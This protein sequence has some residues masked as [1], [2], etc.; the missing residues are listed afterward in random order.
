M[1]HQA[2]IFNFVVFKKEFVLTVAFQAIPFINLSV[3]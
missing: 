1:N 3:S 2:L